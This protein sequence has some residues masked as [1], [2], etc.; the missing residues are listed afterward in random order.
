MLSR[1]LIS[2]LMAVR[3]GER[4]L[5]EALTSI[6]AQTYKELEVIVV[7]DASNDGTK[8]IIEEYAKSD[9]RV[10]YI[11]NKE[12]LGL[13]RSLN[14][15]LGFA[16]GEFLA[17]QDADDLSLPDRIELQVDFLE[18]N[19]QVGVLGSAYFLI[20]DRG[21]VLKTKHP[22]QKD[23]KIRWHLLFHNPFC[24]SSIM[25][26]RGL[27][28]WPKVGYDEKWSV[29]QDYEL[30][31]RLLEC[32]MA[33][34]LSRPLVC[35]R[36][37]EGQISKRH[38]EEQNAAADLI[39]AEALKKICGKS[40]S[41]E[42]VHALRILFESFPQHVNMEQAGLLT[43]FLEVLECFG[44]QSWVS[45]TEFSRI[46]AFWLARI[47]SAAPR[48]GLK[49]GLWKRCARLSVRY[50]AAFCVGVGR[51]LRASMLLKRKDVF[52]ERIS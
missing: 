44:R 5:R 12:H 30:W 52:K 37:H 24:H 6:L 17:R 1:P 43:L 29:A 39:S 2:L 47:V 31:S 13:A 21:R 4:H 35:L 8:S 46:R 25:V 11:Q 19:P 34:N 38:N 41:L 7:D 40:F 28:E 33:A 20:D 9:S 51:R 36:I 42:E 48:M 32:T 14:K 45:K 15:G 10:I 22:P 23:T 50:P 27:L 3:N 26:R 49:G 18:K 16:R